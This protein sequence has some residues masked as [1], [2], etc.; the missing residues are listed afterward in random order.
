MPQLEEDWEN[1]QFT[2]ADTNF[3]N[4]HNTHSKSKRIQKK[5]SEH[6]LDL[7]DNQYYSEE[8]PSVQ[9]QYSI[10]DPDYYRPQLRRSHTQP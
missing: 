7:T 3:I 6:L 1:S 4:R 10:P 2:Y 5:Y 8:Y 9:L